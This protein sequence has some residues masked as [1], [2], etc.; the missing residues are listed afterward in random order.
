VCP[1]ENC[2]KTV[3]IMSA[4]DLYWLRSKFTVEFQ[5]LPVTSKSRGYRETSPLFKSGVSLSGNDTCNI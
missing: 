1:I 2:L 4:W 5:T 3:L